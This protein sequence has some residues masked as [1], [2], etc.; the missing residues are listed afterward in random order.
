MTS[1]ILSALFGLTP[2]ASLVFFICSLAAFIIAKKKNKTE[3]DTYTP[4]QIKTRKILLIVSSVILGF[5]V[6]VIVG[7]IAI[8]ATAVIFM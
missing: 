6:A 3:P 1:Y 8:L 5:I 4:E 7:F 2:I